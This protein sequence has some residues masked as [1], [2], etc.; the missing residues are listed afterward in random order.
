MSENNENPR[1]LKANEEDTCNI[2]KNS[3]NN[4]LKNVKRKIRKTFQRKFGDEE[5]PKNNDAINDEKSDKVEINNE[6]NIEKGKFAL[7]K[8]FRKS[9]FRKIIAN[10]QQITNFTVS[11]FFI[12]TCDSYSIY[13]MTW[14][15]G[16]EMEKK[17]SIVRNENKNWT[18]SNDSQNCFRLLLSPF[19]SKIN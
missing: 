11:T 1:E 16:K 13:S 6:E 8:I 10:I 12:H 9:S 19:H 3:K 4:T 15:G 2:D 18:R 7:K 14:L 5:K 17:L